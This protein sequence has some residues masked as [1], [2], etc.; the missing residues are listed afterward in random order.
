MSTENDKCLVI[1][2]SHAGTQV[3]M[4]LRR[5]GWKGVVQLL[6]DEPGYPYHRPPLSKD[7]LKGLKNRDSMRLFGEAVYEKQRIDL[8]TGHRAIAIDRDLQ[9][10]ALDNG[11]QL[12]YSKLVLAVGA[13][14]LQLGVPGANLDNVH[15]L[16]TVAD[17]DRIRTRAVKS[18]RAIVIGGGYIGLEVA[19]SLRML[20]IEVTVLEAMDRILQ[21]VTSVQVSEFFAGL[22]REEGVDIRVRARVSAVHETESGLSAE[23]ESGEVIDTDLIVAGI[24]ITPNVELA[25]NA[26]LPVSDGI[27]VDE[28]AR[29]SDPDIYAIGD[30][31]YFPHPGYGRRLRLESVQNAHDQAAVAAESII[32]VARPYDPV[33]WFWSDQYD[34]KLQIAGIAHDPDAVICRPDAEDPRKMAVLYIRDGCLQAVDAMNRPK[35]YLQGRKLIATRDVLDLEKLADSDCAL[36]DAVS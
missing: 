5:L 31:A 7:Y 27:E 19:A 29:T 11:D 33:P 25:E 13:R 18:K 1:G 22:H 21:R 30:C 35:D 3:A 6:G 15:Y 4:R 26:G 28:Y 10:V 14:P 9:S 20:G 8:V 12:N 34:V 36:L 2:A 23:L 24:G 16:R 17:V 32:G